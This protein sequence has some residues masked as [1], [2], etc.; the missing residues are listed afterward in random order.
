MNELDIQSYQLV[1]YGDY[2]LTPTDFVEGY[3]IVGFND[4][5]TRRD[6]RVGSFR[7]TARGDFDSI[8][9]RIYTGLGRTYQQSWY[10]IG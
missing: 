1:L 9:T 8:F 5:E 3:A 10:W 7:A 4:N 2:D 6:M